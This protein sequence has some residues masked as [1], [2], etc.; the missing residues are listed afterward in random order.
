[1]IFILVLDTS[2]FQMFTSLKSLTQF[3]QRN[4]EM[5]AHER[6]IEKDT[7][8]HPCCRTICIFIIIANIF[9]VLTKG[10]DAQLSRLEADSVTVLT[11]VPTF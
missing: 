6:K 11:I 2:G 10:H 9:L 3:Y 4:S 1:M 7:N 8:R 5:N